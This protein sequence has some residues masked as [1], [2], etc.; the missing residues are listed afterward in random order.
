MRLAP[1][2][3]RDSGAEAGGFTDMG[4]LHYG[5]TIGGDGINRDA[6]GGVVER[7]LLRRRR[8]AV[9]AG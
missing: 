8:E 5:V 3:R 2:A 9:P 6:E 1:A 7:D 4:H